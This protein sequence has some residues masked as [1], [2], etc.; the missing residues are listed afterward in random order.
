MPGGG[1]L[2]TLSLKLTQVL[3]PVQTVA[4][5]AVVQAAPTPDV[6]TPLVYCVALP[7]AVPPEQ[8]LP[9]S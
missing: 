1:R 7:G 3:P 9:L 2:W 6:G 8:K 5:L 4:W